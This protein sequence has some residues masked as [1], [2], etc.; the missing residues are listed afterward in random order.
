MVA[1]LAD[2][3]R[4]GFRRVLNM[5][6][7]HNLFPND[8]PFRY[9]L[10]PRSFYSTF[11]PEI[12]RLRQALADDASR[13]WFDRILTFRL[14]G[15]YAILPP[16]SLGD[17]YCPADVPRWIDPIRFVDCG[18]FDGDTIAQFALRDG[19]SFEWIVAF[20]PEPS[21]FAKLAKRVKN[22][23]CPAVSFPCGVGGSTGLVGFQA[24]DGTASRN[25]EDGNVAIQCVTLDEA[26]GNF[27][28]TLIKMDIEG[29]EVEALLGARALISDARPGLAISL[30][31]KPEDLW[32]IPLTLLAWN[33]A[34]KFY[35][36]GHAH[37]SFESVLY[38]IPS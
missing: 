7:F 14:S 6:D 35:I 34:Y 9:W 13:H 25:T 29:S 1:A 32:Q 21:N 17:Q 10:A 23:G 5:V 20:E 3:S 37:N 8:Q 30:Y 11:V 28:P 27:Q 12:D 15:D 33:L 36:R 16:P 22:Y 18:A 26:L 31:H 19:F 38:A 4:M 2:V 24:G